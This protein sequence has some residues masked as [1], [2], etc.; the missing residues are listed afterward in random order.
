MRAFWPDKLSHYTN[1]ELLGAGQ[2]GLVYLVQNPELKQKTIIK[3]IEAVRD[4]D[5]VIIRLVFLVLL[6]EFAKDG[7]WER[8]DVNFCADRR[9]IWRDN[10]Q[11]GHWHVF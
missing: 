5:P 7:E 4:I 8:L 3:I 11:P 9:A 6:F 2:F 1:R 10:A